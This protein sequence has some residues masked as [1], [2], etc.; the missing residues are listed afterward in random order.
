MKILEKIKNVFEKIVDFFE[1][2][3]KGVPETNLKLKYYNKEKFNNLYHYIIKINKDY[4]IVKFYNKYSK[5]IYIKIYNK[6]REV[7]KYLDVSSDSLQKEEWKA[8]IKLLKKENL[9]KEFDEYIIKE[10][11]KKEEWK[12]KII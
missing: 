1:Y 6:K 10:N 5:K 12:E 2:G 4:R 3:M 8:L 7:F 11:N 9:Y